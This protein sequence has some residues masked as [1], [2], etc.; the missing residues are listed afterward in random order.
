MYKRRTHDEFVKE[1]FEVNNKIEVLGYFQGMTKKISIRCK[2][3]DREWSTLPSNLLSGHGCKKCSSPIR[4]THEEFINEASKKNPYVEIVGQYNGIDNPILV[5]C[6]LCGEIYEIAKAQGV[7]KGHI[8]KPCVHKIKSHKGQNVKT[9]LQFIEEIKSLN[10]NVDVLSEYVNHNTKVLVKCRDCGKER[11]VYPSVLLRLNGTGCYKCSMEV[12]KYKMRKSH[13]DFIHE[14]AEINPHIEILSIY[15]KQ[16]ADI[17]IKCKVCGY[18][19]YKNASKLLNRTYNCPICSDKIS[20]PNKFMGSLLNENKID[21]ESE[22]IFDWS[23]NKRYDF[24]IPSTS[25]IIEMNGEQHYK[26]INKKSGWN[27]S[28]DEIQYNDN[29]KK[30]LALS[31]G[32]KNYIEIDSS[33]SLATYITN[34]IRSSEI[35]FLLDNINISDV[36]KKCLLQSKIMDIVNLYNQGISARQISKRI[37]I[38]RNTCNSYIKLAKEA[39]LIV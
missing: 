5:K 17:L 33:Q 23:D 7:L 13:E 37:G 30:E 36:L 38:S 29:Y 19:H 9:H 8:H 18:E 34:S 22:K 14:V 1:L 27:C 24:Y 32:I 21:F 26:E 4:K 2:Q 12:A 20:F 3:C 31:N 11:W 15:T 39:K 35:S 28:L 6:L 25:T 16:D 10:K